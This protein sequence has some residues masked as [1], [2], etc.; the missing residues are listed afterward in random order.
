MKK[1]SLE[2]AIFHR[3]ANYGMTNSVFFA[4]FVHL[5]IIICSQ[6]LSKSIV[7]KLVYFQYYILNIVKI[8]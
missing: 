1:H 6:I 8:V 2:A 5:L 3:G 7:L 4:D